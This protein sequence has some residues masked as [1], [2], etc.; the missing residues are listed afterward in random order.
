MSAGRDVPPEE[1][2]SAEHPVAGDVDVLAVHRQALRESGD[3]GEGAEKGPWWFWAAA[4]LALVF[5]GFYMGRYS[6]TFSARVSVHAQPGSTAPRAPAAASTADVSG[7]A[8][9][10]G[11][12]AACHQAIGKCLKIRAKQAIAV[13][14]R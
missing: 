5:G 9:Y 13:G 4:V 6:G 1:I 3:P 11:R 7:R 2:R 14:V 8:V 10:D 12:C